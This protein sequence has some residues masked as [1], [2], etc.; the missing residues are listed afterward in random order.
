VEYLSEIALPQQRRDHGPLE[1]VEPRK[2]LMIQFRLLSNSKPRNTIHTVSAIYR[3]SINSSPDY[4]H[5]LQK[6]YVDYKYIF[7]QNVTQLKKFFYNTLVYFNM[8]SF[9]CTENV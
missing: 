4:K 3:V 9:C 8:C 1:D 5:L 7:F 6:K 2:K